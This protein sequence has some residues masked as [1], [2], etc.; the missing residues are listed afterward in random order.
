LSVLCFSAKATTGESFAIAFLWLQVSIAASADSLQIFWVNPNQFSRAGA[1][2]DSEALLRSADRT[3]G[4][5]KHF[6]RLTHTSFEGWVKISY[7]PHAIACL[8]GSVTLG[9]RE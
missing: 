3:L 9:C 7:V 2:R 8:Q 1:T 4:K 5:T 6:Q